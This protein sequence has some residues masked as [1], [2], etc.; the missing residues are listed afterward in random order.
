MKVLSFNSFSS[1][2]VLVL[3][4]LTLLFAPNVS[5]SLVL[6]IIGI[7]K[8]LSAGFGL[9]A[10]HKE[11]VQN[12]MLFNNYVM[13]LIFGLIL[14]FVPK[15]VSIVP[16][17]FGVF[18]VVTGVS[19]IS[20]SFNYKGTTSNWWLYLIFGIALTLLGLYCITNPINLIEDVIRII[21]V[22]ILVKGGFIIYNYIKEGKNENPNV[23][24]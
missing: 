23:I 2:I 6:N 11:N 1:G 14:L 10:M 3:L 5:I 7:Y 4:G 15:I 17:I 18:V 19:Q 24:D 8:C 20:T 13:N 21:G 16:M 12:S 9:Y 22:L